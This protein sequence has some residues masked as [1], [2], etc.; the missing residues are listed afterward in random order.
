MLLLLF[1]ALAGLLIS[2]TLFSETCYTVKAF[3]L[4]ASLVPSLRGET[5][6]VFPPLGRLRAITHRAPFLLEITLK[7]V[8]IDQLSASLR[9]LSSS[10]ALSFLHHEFQEKALYFLLRLSIIT[11]FCA[12]L[13]V[14][15][16]LRRGGRAR[17]IRRAAFCG[18]LSVLLLAL[19]IGST[20]IYPYN[21]SAF[22]NPRFE[23]AL[24]AAPWIIRLA[25]QAHDTVTALSGQLELVAL[26]LE[27][28]SSRLDRFNP[29]PESGE[30]RVLHVSDIHNNPA[31]FDFI[32]KVTGSFQI[33][34]II[35]TGDLTDYGSE[36]ETE[37]AGR[38]AGLDLPYVFVPGNHD[39]LQSIEM[40]RREGAIIVGP[41]P[42][43]IAGLLI[44]GL[45]DPAAAKETA[46]VASE[47]VMLRESRQAR[48][49]LAEDGEIPDIFAVHNPLMAEPF[50]GEMPVILCGHTHSAGIV[51]DD[52]NGTVLANAG[53]TGAAG[54]RGLLA[55]HKNPYSAVILYFNPEAGGALRLTSL[56]LISIEQLQDSFT[57]QRFYNRLP[58]S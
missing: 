36:L 27:E 30:I 33:D 58:D 8:D 3:E 15:L 29:L 1:L 19:I 14:L 56:D 52:G 54:V 40:L 21:S 11:F 22:E 12:A 13:F 2:V 4:T 32:E 24:A 16:I 45:A 44:A 31:A 17:V 46:E 38:L 55:P 48:R 26:N 28:I 42:V 47:S 37:L 5:V 23:G 20:L 50:M 10:P 35:D 6:F 25:E 39:T 51:F 7:N 18:L 49:D 41:R 53:T 43:E 9:E 34:L 57:L